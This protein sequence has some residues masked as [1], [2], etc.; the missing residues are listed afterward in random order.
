MET[1]YYKV[2]PGID[3][4]TSYINGTVNIMSDVKSIKSIKCTDCGCTYTPPEN[5]KYEDYAPKYCPACGRKMVNWKEI[6][7]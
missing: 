6:K 7:I 1:R 5:M 4:T 2:F 3:L